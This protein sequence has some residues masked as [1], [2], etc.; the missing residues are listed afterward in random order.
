MAPLRNGQVNGHTRVSPPEPGATAGKRFSDIPSAIDIPV[1]SGLDAEEAVEVNLEELHDDPT[2]L[3]TLLENE[4]AARN[5]W[6]IIALAYAKQ[7]KVDHA[8][9]LLTK[10]LAA[11]SKGG[12]KDKLGLLTCLCW[13]YLWK[14]REAPRVV[15]EGQLVSE[16]LTKD[17]FLQQSTATLNE[18][19]RINPSFPPL[20]L[21]RGVLYL[22]R[23]SLQPPSRSLAPDSAD[24]SER[25]ET[26]RQ[27][28]KCFEDAIRV[29][30]GRNMMAM[31]GKAR[32]LYSLGKYADALESYQEVLM[33]MPDLR[34]PDSRIGIGCCLWQLG[35][36]EEARDA[37]ERALELVGSAV[38]AL[39]TKL[40]Y[41]RTLSRKL[42]PFWSDCTGSTTALTMP[43]PIQ[44]LLL[45][46]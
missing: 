25:V 23:A 41:C 34:D 10:G 13:L 32:A 42:R 26:L 24:H 5:F 11:L 2:E 17:Y 20:F 30:V 31:L 29:S 19:S 14:S 21:A 37:W 27:A 40:T 39:N 15:P 43:Q 9:E 6:M 36:K 28:L 18:A 45:C 33:K 38:E 8:I 12:I 22:L 16:A 1:S 7:R 46:T 3:C 35:F 4:G 44:L